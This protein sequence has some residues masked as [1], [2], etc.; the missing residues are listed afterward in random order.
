MAAALPQVVRPGDEGAAVL[1]QAVTT[2]SPAAE[3]QVAIPAVA[4]DP[5]GRHRSRRFL[6]EHRWTV[7][8]FTAGAV[9]RLAAMWVWS[10]DIDVYFDTVRF[11]RVGMP[12]FGDF[13]MP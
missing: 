9:V 3:P 13:W 5:A 10:P 12:F 11:A 1:P 2:L 8:L 7:A 4:A 6:A